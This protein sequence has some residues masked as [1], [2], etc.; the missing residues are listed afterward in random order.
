M[1]TKDDPRKRR[2]AVDCGGIAAGLTRLL[3]E[4]KVQQKYSLEQ[5]NRLGYFTAQQLVESSGLSRSAISAR[6]A[7][8]DKDG[9]LDRLLIERKL[10]AFKTRP[11]SRG[12]KTTVQ[13]Q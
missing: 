12:Q 2:A 3:S 11:L 8:M 9:R 10:Y 5:A 7:S 4:L 13:R 1:A 6:L